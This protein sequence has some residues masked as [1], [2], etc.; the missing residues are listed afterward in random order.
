MGKEEVSI[1]EKY[2]L[3]VREAALY[4]NIGENKMRQIIGANPGAKYLLMKGNVVMIK[5]KLFE[6]FLDDAAVI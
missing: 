1:P 4:F 2:L 5:R 3:T 6:K